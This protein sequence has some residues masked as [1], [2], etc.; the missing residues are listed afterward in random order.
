MNWS[1]VIVCAVC[2]A[3]GFGYAA[4]RGDAELAQAQLDAAIER[5]NLGKD[6]YAKLVK[7]QNELEAARGDSINLR[8]EL[9]RVRKSYADRAR[10]ADSAGSVACP[11]NARC[12]DL[13]RRS[14][15]LLTGCA[16]LLQRNAA[17]HDAL[18]KAVK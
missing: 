11:A 6:Y 14:T 8:G 18:A 5:A 10:K 1:N 3:V 7:A 17:Q 2:F 16:E 12:E 15:E 9:E 4:Y 13:L